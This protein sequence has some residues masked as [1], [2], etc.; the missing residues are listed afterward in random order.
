MWEVTFGDDP[1]S[2]KYIKPLTTVF[3]FKSSQ[4]NVLNITDSDWKKI[5]SMVA[6]KAHNGNKMSM[7]KNHNSIKT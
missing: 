6:C 5:L 1:F 2:A 4:Q 3:F 7:L